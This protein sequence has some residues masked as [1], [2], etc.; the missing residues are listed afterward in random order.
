MS[1]KF[2]RFAPG[3][4]YT[5]KGGACISAFVLV[6]KGDSLLLGKIGDPELWAEKW[7]LALGYPER[8]KDKWQI[9]ASYLRFGEHP[10]EAA[11]RV[12]KDQLK[13]GKSE[14][15]FL[16]L[17]SHA[18]DS[19]VSP[20]N[21]HWDLC[22]IY[23]SKTDG[24]LESPEWFKELRFFKTNELPKTDMGRGHGDLIATLGRSWNST[25]IW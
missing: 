7:G 22:F 3:E 21:L 17:Q 18:A 4:E 8:W 20:G 25:I 24:P 14:M 5:P 12:V 11:E 23:E 6:R 1:I 13:I 16:G 15:R 9:P 19:S 2:A 10:D